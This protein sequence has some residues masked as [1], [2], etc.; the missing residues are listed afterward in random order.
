MIGSGGNLGVY[1]KVE[2]T[3]PE[4]WVGNILEPE[5]PNPVLAFSKVAAGV[6]CG[7]M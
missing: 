4:I 1:S 6:S 2:G 7:E 3:H 5:S